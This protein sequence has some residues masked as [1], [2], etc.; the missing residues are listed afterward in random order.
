[1][2]EEWEEVKDK[3]I[4]AVSWNQNVFPLKHVAEKEELSHRV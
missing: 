3:E 4:S 2:Q 1:M